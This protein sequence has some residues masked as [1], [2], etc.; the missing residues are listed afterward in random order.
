MV[1]RSGAIMPN[2]KSN[3]QKTTFSRCR[4]RRL[5]FLSAERVVQSV[6]DYSTTARY[7]NLISDKAHQPRLGKAVRSAH[8]AIEDQAKNDGT[9]EEE[10]LGPEGGLGPN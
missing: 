3:C 7:D 4:K 10:V 6:G 2:S 9:E 8:Q 5:N 1:S